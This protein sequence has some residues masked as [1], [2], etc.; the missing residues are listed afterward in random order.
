MRVDGIRKA[1]PLRYFPISLVVVSAVYTVDMAVGTLPVV[2][3]LNPITMAPY[4]QVQIVGPV[5]TVG[6]RGILSRIEGDPNSLCFQAIAEPT[7][8]Y[9]IPLWNGYQTLAS[10]DTVQCADYAFPGAVNTVWSWEVVGE[11]SA[12]VT[13][14]SQ[15][16][17]LTGTYSRIRQTLD[18]V[19]KA[20]VPLKPTVA[21][22]GSTTLGGIY[23]VAQ[24]YEVV[25]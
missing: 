23:L 4:R 21:V 11:G 22:T 6:A 18:P 24:S 3:C 1:S 12:T 8:E 7:V 16:I 20:G 9:Y 25:S 10:G 13:L 17:A 2:N 15:T 19:P 5:P 14:Q